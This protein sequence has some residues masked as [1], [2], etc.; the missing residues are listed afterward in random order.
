MQSIDAH[1]AF[2]KKHKCKPSKPFPGE[3]LV[4]TTP[5]K[6]GMF[7]AAA[8]TSGMSLNKWVDHMLE[9][10]LRNTHHL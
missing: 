1:L 5:E 7:T 8:K 10:A 3:F 2:C 6:H 9:N 4:R